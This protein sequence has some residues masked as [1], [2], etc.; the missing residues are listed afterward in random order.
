MKK[1]SDALPLFRDLVVMLERHYKIK[2][3]ILHT[4]FGEFNSDAANN[5]LNQTGITWEPSAPNAQQQN[6]IVERHMRT[7][8]EGA[9]AQMIDS[10][11]PLKLSAESINT[12]VYIKNRPPISAVHEGTITPIQDFHRGD[13][14]R[15]DHIR[16]FGSEAHVL[17]E[18]SNCP[19]LTSKA[20]TGYLV[21][22]GGRNQYRI[23]DP[24]RHS[25]FIR[26][27]VHFN[28]Q[29]IGPSQP[30]F[31]VDSLPNVDGSDYSCIFPMLCSGSGD[32][33]EF[34]AADTNPTLNPASFLS[35]SLPL[36]A[37]ET[38]ESVL[39]PV[40]ALEHP[41]LS[42][43]TLL[44]PNS[45][46]P[47]STQTPAIQPQPIIPNTETSNRNNNLENTSQHN[48]HIPGGFDNS[49][50]EALS[51][52]PSTITRDVSPDP[53]PVRRSARTENH[54]IDYKLFFRGGKAANA[55]TNFSVPHNSPYSQASRELFDYAL[56]QPEQQ[57]T[58]GFVRIA[59]K[60]AK[61]ST[62]DMP[63]LKDALKSKEA[64]AWREAM[65][66]EYEALIANGTWV[67][68]D[69]PKDQHVLTRKWAFKRKRDIDG[70]IKKYKARWVG[71]GFQQQ[72]GIDYF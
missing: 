67:L 13:L 65:R 51:D 22:Y 66:T 17:E 39:L 2:V 60:K 46:A 68:V 72:E 4:D 12:M 61:A 8:V 27:D 1:K 9:R 34:T 20:W 41:V 69:R 58:R 33:T 19:G 25:V 29:A 30:M 35:Q 14:P 52:L 32:L 43:P 31:E 24:S 15:V 28:E 21:G 38:Q 63:S 37:I 11:L 44:H 18:S 62:P 55:K 70:N 49:D 64:D 5:Y 54:P 57:S 48:D 26:R 50:N 6:G 10:N 56:S 16:I 59:R 40:S 23:Y 42:S 45:A 36:P 47:T 3:C 71:R 53:A 7:V